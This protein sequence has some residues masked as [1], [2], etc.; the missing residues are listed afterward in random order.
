LLPSNNYNAAGFSVYGGGQVYLPGKFQLSSYINYNYQAAVKT[1]PAVYYKMLNATLSKAF[2][3][4]DNLKFSITGN[5]LLNQNQNQRNINA[6][7]FTQNTYNSIQRY[8]MLN[9]TW[10]FT[11]FGTGT[12][13]NN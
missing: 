8:F 10:D 12:T 3:K 13:A 6:T 1:A 2:F 9:I 5:N 7:G 11:K 4:G